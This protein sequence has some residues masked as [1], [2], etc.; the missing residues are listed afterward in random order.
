M[1][2]MLW[3]VDDLLFYGWSLWQVTA[4]AADSSGGFPLRMQRVPMGQWQLERD[5]GRVLTYQPDARGGWTLQPAPARSVVLIPG[6]ARG[7]ARRWRLDAA[8]RADLERSA[9]NAARHPSAYLGLKQT[10][11]PPLKRSSDD[12]AEVTVETILA[13]WRA[14]R[15]NPEGGGVAWLGGVEPVELGTFA[16]HMLESGPQRCRRRRRPARSIP[17]DLIDATVSESSLHYSTSRDNDRRFIDYGLGLYMGAISG[18]LTQD[19]VTPRGQRVGSTPS[20]G[21]RA[22]RRCPGS[23]PRR[24]R[25]DPGAPTRP[26]RDWRPR[27][28][29]PRSVHRRHAD[30]RG[31]HRPRTPSH[32]TA[33][34]ILVPYGVP[35]RTNL[36]PKRI[37]PR[38]AAAWSPRRP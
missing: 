15:N 1:H 38:C 37:R 23:S 27:S 25:H 34:G 33:E 14:A 36:G 24:R 6:P 20:S 5:T 32:R 28:E 11:G 22:R 12:P 31:D 13:D 35:G 17:A 7:A 30:R 8:A 21:S 16:E 2:R 9:H 10:S 3:T 19:D 29:R 18:R 26:P 4:R